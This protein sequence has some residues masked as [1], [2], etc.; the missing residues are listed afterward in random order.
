MRKTDSSSASHFRGSDGWP[1]ATP[2]EPPR[3]SSL[4][5]ARRVIARYQAMPVAQAS[6]AGE[7]FASVS[8]RSAS[9]NKTQVGRGDA[10]RDTRRGGKEGVRPGLGVLDFV[11]DSVQRSAAPVR[12]PPWPRRPGVGAGW[13]DGPRGLHCVGE[14]TS[15]C[16][17]AAK[18]MVRR[19]RRIDRIGDVPE[20]AADGHP[21]VEAFTRPRPTPA[22]R[23]KWLREY[24]AR[25]SVTRSSR[26][27][28]SGPP[29]RRRRIRRSR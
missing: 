27:T 5:S 9:V 22:S 25:N 11:D 10:V 2:A 23:P 15:G 1:A 24:H 12:R 17:V 18:P 7:E 8:R 3:P 28:G 4:P 16:F 20:L 6:P 13:T 19:Q 14:I 21:G 29:M 26:R